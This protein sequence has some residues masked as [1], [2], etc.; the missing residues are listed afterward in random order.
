MNPELTGEELRWMYS[1]FKGEFRIIPG[2]IVN[3]IVSKG[4]G[5]PNLG[6]AFNLTRAGKEV[7]RRT[8]QG[9]QAY[10]EE[11]EMHIIRSTARAR[12]NWRL[13]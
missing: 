8:P 11:E 12:T 2:R 7:F 5:I 10:E 9:Y 4:L 3:S 1:V 13:G 6:G